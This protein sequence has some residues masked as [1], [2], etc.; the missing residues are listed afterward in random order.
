[1][2]DVNGDGLGDIYFPN[3]VGGNQ[4]WKN[5][6]SIQFAEITSPV[7]D[8]KGHCSGAIFFDYNRDGELDLFLANVG[9]YTTED[10]LPVS[11]VPG[12]EGTE[13]EYYRGLADAFSGHLMPERTE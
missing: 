12:R 13:Y 6:G 1:M 10:R 3:Q 2:A 4:L 5:L 8:H 7:L 9:V 11:P